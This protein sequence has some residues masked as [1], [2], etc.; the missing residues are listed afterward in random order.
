VFYAL[1][2]TG[3][4]FRNDISHIQTLAFFI[5][6]L[7]LAMTMFC[8]AALYESSKNRTQERLKQEMDFSNSAINSLPGVFYVLD[9]NGRHYRWNNNLETITG[10]SHEELAVLKSPDLM[11]PED[12]PRVQN[13]LEEVIT[14]GTA[15]AELRLL[16]K[17]GSTIPY[18]CKG[19][20]IVID[21]RTFII[22]TGIDISERKQAED[23]M[24]ESE[25]KFRRIIQ[26]S[27]MGM[28]LYELQE[29]DRLV[30]IDCNASADRHTGTQNR[31][32]IGKTIEEAFPAL[33]ETQVP[34]RYRDV[35]R[36]GVPWHT[37]DLAY[38]DH[39]IK[40]AY[41]VYA[42]QTSPGRM[43]VM[44]LDITDRTRAEQER[45]HTL[46]LLRATLESTADG[47]L[48][49]NS[50]RE[51]VNFNKKFQEMWR[52]PD[53]LITC[54]TNH[55]ALDFV[56]NQVEDPEAFLK[57]VNELYEDSYATSFDILR[58][59]D[60][61]IFERFSKPQIVADRSVGRVWSFRDVTARDQAEQNLQQA[62]NAAESANRAKSEFLANM[63]HEIRTPMTAILGFSDMLLDP[64][65]AQDTS[66]ECKE[67]LLTIKRNGEYL[68]GIINDILDLSKIEAG[69]MA[70]EKI[71]FSPSRILEEVVSMLRARAEAKNLALTL[72]FDGAIPETIRSDPKRLRQI[73][74]NV[75]SNAIKFT[76]VGSVRLIAR[77]NREA[78]EPRL[79]ID[80]VDT[81]IGM[82]PEHVTNLFQPFTQADASMSRRFGG[83]GLGLS[84]TKRLAQ[85]LG[86]DA[87]IVES[88]PQ[89]GTHFRI[90]VAIDPLD[91]VARIADPTDAVKETDVHHCS[92]NTSTSDHLP[93]Q[94]INILLAEDGPDNQRLISRLL[95]KAGGEVTITENGLAAIEAVSSASNDHRPFDVILMDMQMPVMDGYR[96]TKQLRDIGCRTRIIAL[97]AHAM[98]GDREKCLM[99]GCDDYTTK[100][101]NRSQLIEAILRNTRFHSDAQAAN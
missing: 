20:R 74:I 73:L 49:V 37:T 50:D 16:T 79:E 80:V 12:A 85:I 3:Y 92:E 100:P 82:S 43:A 13:A 94:G 83:T 32:L 64:V 58:L 15:S 17:D 67:A 10:R 72:Q 95:A 26:A 89:K 4:P 52:I 53:E 1:H 61:R 28:F 93:L 99:A 22:G 46:S 98:D 45:E 65:H 27:P 24:R 9:E 86:G 39:Q 60:G 36:T 18:Y 56:M 44:F 25:E 30:L 11:S 101:V 40:G 90:L 7:G 84:I 29:N 23:A 70:V 78:I 21:G 6:L 96:A 62:K 76:D 5:N 75:V 91:H 8:V 19:S 81:G 57:K 71:I 68:L 31:L 42:F 59:K 87:W 48:V 88:K 33:T 14:K 2:A 41:D 69:K 54:E 97:T 38:E 47:I 77:L 35:A 63:S 51:F 55:Q 34:D 66:K